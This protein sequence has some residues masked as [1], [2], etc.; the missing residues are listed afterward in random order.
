MLVLMLYHVFLFL[1]LATCFTLVTV[2]NLVVSDL[3]C[4][5]KVFVFLITLI[6]LMLISSLLP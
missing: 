6:G 2:F 1:A 5:V 4:I 3:P